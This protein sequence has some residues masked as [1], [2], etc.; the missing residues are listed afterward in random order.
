MSETSCITNGCACIGGKTYQLTA[1]EVEAIKRRHE[2]TKDPFWTEDTVKDGDFMHGTYGTSFKKR[3]GYP[4]NYDEQIH[5]LQFVRTHEFANQIYLHELLNRKLLQ[6]AITH[7]VYSK[8]GGWAIRCGVCDDGIRYFYYYYSQ[9]FGVLGAIMF[10][11]EGSAKDAVREVVSPFL[12]EH[13]EMKLSYE[14]GDC[15]V[16]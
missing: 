1:E 14:W 6:Y 9:S 10:D 2:R 4:L 8:H 13:P 3:Y 16:E 12:K 5:D 15:D 7:D 11:R